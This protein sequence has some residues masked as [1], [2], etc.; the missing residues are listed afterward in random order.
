MESEREAT[1]FWKDFA[2]IA[3][4][5]ILAGAGL[6]FFANSCEIKQDYPYRAGI[7]SSPK[8]NYGPHPLK[9]VNQWIL[10]R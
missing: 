7:N 8:I 3:P 9:E 5:A 4:F 1:S 6:A 10:D 2:K